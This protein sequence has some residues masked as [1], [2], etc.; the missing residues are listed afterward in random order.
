MRVSIFYN[1][2]FFFNFNISIFSILY[3]VFVKVINCR[4]EG[5]KK[6]M[7]YFR[8]LFYFCK[9]IYKLLKLY[10]FMNDKCNYFFCYKNLFLLNVNI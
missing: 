10:F 1:G 6:I 7:I 9:L 5:K 3:F 4:I 8:L 2:F